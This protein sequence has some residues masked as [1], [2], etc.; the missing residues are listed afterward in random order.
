MI[1]A[2]RRRRLGLRRLPT[3]LLAACLAALT[4][5]LA[6]PGTA[7]AD[8][9]PTLAPD[10]SLSV[11]SQ[12]AGWLAGSQ[13]QPDGAIHD[14]SGRPDAVATGWSVLAMRAAG[15][16]Q[17]SERPAG[18]LEGNVDALARD[19]DQDSPA[20]LALLV[21][22]ARAENR[23]AEAFGGQDLVARLLATRDPDGLFGPPHDLPGTDPIGG[24]PARQGLVLSA[25]GA[26][27]RTDAGAADWLE[28]R[29]CPDGGWQFRRIDP[30]TPC[31]ASPDV[32]GYAVQGLAAVGRQIPPDA[33]D[34]LARMQRPD[35]GFGLF[36]TRSDAF[37]TALGLQALIAAGQDPNT[38]RWRKGTGAAAATPFQALLRYATDPSGGFSLQPN[39]PPDASWTARVVI[40]AAGQPLPLAASDP[41]LGD[42][43]GA[44]ASDPNA[45]N[46]TGASGSGSSTDS[47]GITTGSDSFS[48]IPLLAG[49]A[50]AL[51]IVGAIY[52]YRRRR[53]A[54]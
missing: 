14:H 43:D 42:Q 25:L 46:T 9:R 36:G 26:A 3:G 19:G 44:A 5:L 54:L 23:P 1:A 27:G 31:Q 47:G 17:E 20:G 32:T 45:S 52:A 30:S 18:W 39:Q 51:G 11:A 38:Q 21:L 35:G 7:T 12:A 41:E 49:G 10:E 40:A 8:T 15:L 24:A 2:D 6:T 22:V 53:Q 13:I 29:Q 4:M 28:M 50:V 16:D 37:G 34:A 48:P 33:I